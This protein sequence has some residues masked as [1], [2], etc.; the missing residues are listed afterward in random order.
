MDN[1]GAKPLYAEVTRAAVFGLVVNLTLGV[2][3]AIAKVAPLLHGQVWQLTYR[4]KALLWTPT[5]E[6][7][8]RFPAGGGSQL[9]LGNPLARLVG[10]ATP[11]K[12]T[13][14]DALS[15][16]NW[17]WGNLPRTMTK[18]VELT[19]D[20]SLVVTAAL[21][22]KTKP[23]EDAATTTV[24]AVGKVVGALQLSYTTAEGEAGTLT[25]SGEQLE[26][27]LPALRVL[28]VPLANANCLVTDEYVRP[29][30]DG[31][32]ATLDLDAGTLTITVSVAA[33]APPALP[34]LPAFERR[35]RLGPLP[36]AP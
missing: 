12:V 20:G 14:E 32:K 2:I 28:R 13:T 4:G 6:K 33:V 18:T 10:E 21:S 27:A 17:R 19:T 7:D 34:D 30:A 9:A 35:V 11:T 8:K 15:V 31:G 1:P 5:D 25:L 22:P 29:A 23:A 36:A 26:Q 3:K 24:Y 16:P